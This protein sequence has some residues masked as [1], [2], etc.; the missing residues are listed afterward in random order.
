MFGKINSTTPLEMLKNRLETNA[1]TIGR[2][3]N[4][5][6]AIFTFSRGFDFERFPGQT[7]RLASVK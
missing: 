7:P 2:E 4:A 1:T 5:T 3:I 6:M